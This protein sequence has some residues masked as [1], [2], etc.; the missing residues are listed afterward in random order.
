MPKFI[1]YHA[2]DNKVGK[3]VTNTFHGQKLWAVIKI[4]AGAVIRQFTIR[5]CAKTSA[6]TIKLA[7]VKKRGT[8]WKG[9]SQE[10]L[11]IAVMIQDG[12]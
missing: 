4:C 8:S 11:G 6:L 10:S 9:V 5:F 12:D 7:D 2:H 1:I 3:Q